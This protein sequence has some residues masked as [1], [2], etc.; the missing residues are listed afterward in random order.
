MSRET[1]KRREKARSLPFM[2]LGASVRYRLTDIEKIEAAAMVQAMPS[3]SA[4]IESAARASGEGAC[5]GN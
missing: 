3:A 2:K 1:L 4:D 5:L